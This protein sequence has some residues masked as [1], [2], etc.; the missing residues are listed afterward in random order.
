MTASPS[1]PPVDAAI[2]ILR[3]INW[4]AVAHRLIMVAATV[5]AVIV[6]VSV[7]TY[8]HARQFWREHGDEITLQ[9]LTFAENAKVVAVT[10]ANATIR[11]VR[12]VAPVV[13]L[14]VNR[15]LDS[16]FY[17]LAAF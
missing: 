1:F 2:G 9:A 11:A 15:A 7:F 4:R 8:R 5:C 17:Q 10:A 6:A 16:A 13:T 3:Q 14:W 12:V